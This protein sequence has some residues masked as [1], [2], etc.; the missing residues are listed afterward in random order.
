MKTNLYNETGLCKILMILFDFERV[1]E[2]VSFHFLFKGGKSYI[3]IEN[4]YFQTQEMKRYE[5]LL[6]VCSW[7]KV[8]L[9][10]AWEKLESSEPGQPLRFY[11]TMHI[12]FNL[13]WFIRCY[14]ASL[15]AQMVKHLPA[16]RETQVW[17]LGEEDPLKKE[18]ATHSSILAW[19]IPWTE[20]PGR[21]PSMG[22]QRVRHDWA[23][24]LT[25]VFICT[26]SV[27]LVMLSNSLTC[28]NDI[29]L[30]T[31]NNSYFWTRLRAL[32]DPFCDFW[33]FI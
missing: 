3:L 11:D 17:S 6:A 23:T 20:E 10:W 2:I 7:A 8:Y 14:R 9:L 24:S 4:I 5:S 13:C 12:A 16:V 26:C 18:M 22:S 19:K 28:V 1:T 15:V 33:V 31:I 25:M 27:G 29:V 21:L 30:L 32:R